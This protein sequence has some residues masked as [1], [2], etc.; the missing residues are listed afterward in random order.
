M[1][2]V[3]LFLCAAAQACTGAACTPPSDKQVTVVLPAVLV[4]VVVLFA[5][6]VALACLGRRGKL[7][8]KCGCGKRAIN[9]VNGN[10]AN[11]PQPNNVPVTASKQVDLDE[12][13]S[14]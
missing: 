8:N 10:H 9:G 6:V 5:V 13:D 4:S 3:C 7:P 14:L 11:G 12:P 2:C 1:T